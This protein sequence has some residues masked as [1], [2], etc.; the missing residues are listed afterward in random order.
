MAQ[1]PSKR[2]SL[3]VNSDVLNGEAPS[4]ADHLAKAVE[5]AAQVNRGKAEDSSGPV[6]GASSPPVKATPKS[7]ADLVRTKA[8]P[9]A[10][11][12]AQATIDDP[13]HTNG[14]IPAK[15]GSLADA[16]SSYNVKDSSDFAK[17]A[18][19]EPRG[20]VN[21]G[22]MC[23]MNSVSLC[24]VLAFRDK[25]LTRNQILQILVFC[26]PFYNF[27]ENI[28]TQAAHSFKSDTPLMDAM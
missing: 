8:A 27:L 2:A 24:L 20:L 26:V 28:G 14:L 15:T 5:A 10:F 1:R 4:N 7:W 13:A 6:E 22:N 3:S 19:L 12:K 21:T 17:V 16:L 25:T 23:Y 18:F 9:T 11:T